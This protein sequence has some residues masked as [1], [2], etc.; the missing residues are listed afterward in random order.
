MNEKE[1][2]EIVHSQNDIII[3]QTKKINFLEEK[4]S[5]LRRKYLRMKYEAEKINFHLPEIF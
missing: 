2:K 5:D 1:L 3:R 4:F